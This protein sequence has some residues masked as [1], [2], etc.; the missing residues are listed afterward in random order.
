MVPNHYIILA[1]HVAI[2][3]NIVVKYHGCHE[4]LVSTEVVSSNRGE[5]T[6]GVFLSRDY[7]IPAEAA[8]G[9]NIRRALRSVRTSAPTEAGEAVG[10]ATPTSGTTGSTRACAGEGCEICLSSGEAVACLTRCMVQGMPL[11]GPADAA[12]ALH[13]LTS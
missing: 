13:G 9:T 5:G 2:H 8:S 1:R 4:S 12:P 6:S 10:L 3:R 7:L 11:H